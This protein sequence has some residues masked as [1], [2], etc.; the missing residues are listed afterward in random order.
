MRRKGAITVLVMVAVALS[1]LAPRAQALPPDPFDRLI[2]E[3]LQD[4]STPTS[5]ELDAFALR[6][7]T[8][9]FL[10]L[11]AELAGEPFPQEPLAQL[12]S[13][14]EAV[15]R[16]SR[17]PRALEYR[18]LHSIPGDLG[19][20]VT[21]QAMVFGNMGDDCGTG[22]CFTRNP[23]TGKKEFYGEFLMNG[24]NRSGGNHG[25]MAACIYY[26]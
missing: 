1:C 14:V 5:D 15:F 6:D 13:A 11:Y 7:L 16:S 20:A 18:R 4:S 9:E 22:V 2:R 8:L 24:I 19:T 12:E 25:A 26:D 10:Q 3:R 21:V 23:S 17:S